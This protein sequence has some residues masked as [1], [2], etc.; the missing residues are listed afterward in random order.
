[1]KEPSP[2]ESTDRPN[3]RARSRW[4]FA[5]ANQFALRCRV[6]FLLVRLFGTAMRTTAARGAVTSVERLGAAE[7]ATAV[8]GLA[9]A[10]AVA[11]NAA[12][13]KTSD[14]IIAVVSLLHVATV[15]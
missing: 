2:S 11:D 10:K 1:M 12:A 15:C 4:M 5:F 14:R 7:G 8:L 6:F 9:G 3:V 13:A